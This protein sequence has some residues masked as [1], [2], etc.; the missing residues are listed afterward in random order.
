MPTPTKPLTQS[1]SEQIEKLREAISGLLVGGEHT[2]ICEVAV[3]R[4]CTCGLIE[5]IQSARDVL[6]LTA[7]V[8]EESEWEGW[9]AF[10]GE[11]TTWFFPPESTGGSLSIAFRLGAYGGWGESSVVLLE[12]EAD[13]GNDPELSS[14][15]ALAFLEQH[16]IPQELLGSSK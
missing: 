11:N 7:P 9:R 6:A 1:E 5:R 10:R 13:S 16:P 3:T 8:A 15:E 14:A 12:C 4:K 2:S